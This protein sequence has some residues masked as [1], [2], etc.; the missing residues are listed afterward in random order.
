[1][2]NGMQGLILG[3]F[4][5]AWLGLVLLLL[6]MPEILDNTLHLTTEARPRGEVVFVLLI[7]AYLLVLA[8]GVVRRWRWT[9][10]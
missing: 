4:A 10:C 7:T 3:F 5:L 2:L 8:I 9:F 1:M 6:G